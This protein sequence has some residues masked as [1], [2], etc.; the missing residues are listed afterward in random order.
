VAEQPW[1]SEIARERA[2]AQ[3]ALEAAEDQMRA[4]CHDAE[5]FN[6]AL[7]MREAAAT[8]LERL[9]MREQLEQEREARGG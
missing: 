6:A 3:V 5:R 4:T 7:R 1:R 2:A 8:E 9:T